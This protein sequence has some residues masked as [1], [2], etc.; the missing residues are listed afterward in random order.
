MAISHDLMARLKRDVAEAR[1]LEISS[2]L[3]VLEAVVT[4]EA[5][6]VK[7]SILFVEIDDG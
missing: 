7:G 1:L 3:R 5:G 2:Q 6:R 4:I